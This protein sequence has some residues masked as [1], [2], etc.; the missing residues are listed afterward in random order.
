MHSQTARNK[1]ETNQ[2]IVV[3]QCCSDRVYRN[4]KINNNFSS[5]THHQG[6][7]T[8]KILMRRWSNCRGRTFKIKP[9]LAVSSEKQ[10]KLKVATELVVSLWTDGVVNA[11][12]PPVIHKRVRRLPATQQSA[13]NTRKSKAKPVTET[14]MKRAHSTQTRTHTHTHTCSQQHTFANVNIYSTNMYCNG[15]STTLRHKPYN[16]DVTFGCS[17]TAWI[18]SIQYTEKNHKLERLQLAFVFRIS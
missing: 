15:Q 12:V 17:K 8:N 2:K 16:T 4:E 6:K 3:R 9:L 18:Y 13:T 11:N 14:N 1:N 5:Q 7:K 10:L